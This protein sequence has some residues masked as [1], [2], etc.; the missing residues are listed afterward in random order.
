MLPL[1]LS[2]KFITMSQHPDTPRPSREFSREKTPSP[3]MEIREFVDGTPKE[4]VSQLLK[5][6][7]KN[8]PRDKRP[9]SPDLVPD[10]DIAALCHE[11]ESM[12][13]KR[14]K[15]DPKKVVW[16]LG[17]EPLPSMGQKT[18]LLRCNADHTL[19]VPIGADQPYASSDDPPDDPTLI[20]H[21]GP[22]LVF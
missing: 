4:D 21:D 16:F 18:K 9:L 6:L 13:V 8:V 17:D 11:T 7:E 15:P 19:G 10:G 20:S 12:S 22:N 14:Q 2:D 5:C 3:K 1:C